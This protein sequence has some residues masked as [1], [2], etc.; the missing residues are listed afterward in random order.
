MF[1]SRSV[2][3]RSICVVQGGNSVLGLY[4]EWIR[5]SFRSS[6]L[7]DLFHRLED[8]VLFINFSFVSTW[9][10]RSNPIFNC[11]LGKW[12]FWD[13]E[14]V[15]IFKIGLKSARDRVHYSYEAIFWAIDLFC[16]QP[17]MSSNFKW[18]M[19]TSWF[20]I[21][22]FQS[23]YLSTSTAICSLWT[24]LSFWSVVF[25]HKNIIPFL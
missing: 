2:W 18:L 5:V 25:F 24:T 19:S 4:G 7:R 9:Q 15:A 3:A 1:V 11:F 14:Q 8:V 20:R 21:L 13:L 12:K 22:F 17:C 6:N 23:L 10:L 16:V